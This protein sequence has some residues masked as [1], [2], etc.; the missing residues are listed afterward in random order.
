ME[1]DVAPETFQESVAE[2]PV[3]IEF[4][5]AAKE[6]I[7]G[8]GVV[9]VTVTVA[10]AVTLPKLLV[11]VSVYIVVTDGATDIEPLATAV[12]LPKPLID[13][14]VAPITFQDNVTGIPGLTDDGDAVNDDIIGV[15]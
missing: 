13:M 9:A 2:P 4:G 8:G 15:F 10:V 6:T 1:T 11:A 5:E 7:V 12:C 14:D 3:V